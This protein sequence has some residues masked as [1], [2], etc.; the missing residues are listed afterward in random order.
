MLS[1][2]TDKLNEYSTEC[3]L[4]L[5]DTSFLLSFSGGIDST[6]MASLLLEMRDAYKFKLGFAH[7]NH[8]SHNK[9]GDLK[10]FCLQYSHD[11]DVVFHQ[12]E[13]FFDSERNFEACAREKRYM[14]LNNI[15]EKYPYQ[16][17]LTAHHQDDQ[18]ETVYMKKMDGADWIS[19]IG[20][21]EKMGKLRRPFLYISKKNSCWCL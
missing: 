8:H 15:A 18:L 14:I 9:S 17:I 12:H 10:K 4:Q 20:I 13:L 11:N 7:F 6:T 19:Q 3:K 2:L 21:R 16:F 1:F 5:E